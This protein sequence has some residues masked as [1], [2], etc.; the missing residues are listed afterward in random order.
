MAWTVSNVRDT[1]LSELS[2]EDSSTCRGEGGSVRGSVGVCDNTA[3]IIVNEIRAV[4]GVDD[5]A[6]LHGVGRGAALIYPPLCQSPITIKGD[7]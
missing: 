3:L 6:R 5:R 2:H 1:L 7:M 4:G